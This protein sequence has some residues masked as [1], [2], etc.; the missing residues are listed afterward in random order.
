M[1]AV[2][3]VLKGLALNCTELLLVNLG[4]RNEYHN[5]ARALGKVDNMGPG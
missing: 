2:M 1:D 4:D 3:R 5:G